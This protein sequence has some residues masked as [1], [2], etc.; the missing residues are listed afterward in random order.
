MA[1]RTRATA[2]EPPPC[3]EPFATG[4]DTPPV[5]RQGV[6]VF[7]ED[8]EESY[9]SAFITT[10]RQCARYVRSEYCD[11]EAAQF[12]QQ[13]PGRCA[14][15]VS[16]EAGETRRGIGGRMLQ[17]LLDDLKNQGVVNVYLHAMPSGGL[18]R[19]DLLRFYRKFGFADKSTV[20]SWQ[21]R[22]VAPFM[23][24]KLRAS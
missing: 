20:Q 13:Q 6:S 18:S 21:G 16:L 3:A 17:V 19:E 2:T 24:K 23:M 22:L 15:V 1:R 7:C 9:A 8:S 12:I 4:W 5:G 14:Y 11:S 10:P